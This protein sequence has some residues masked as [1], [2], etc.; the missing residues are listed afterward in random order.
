MR[1]AFL[2]AGILAM[3]TAQVK[4]D[5]HKNTIGNSVGAGETA[6][7]DGDE[8]VPITGAIKAVSRGA[9]IKVDYLR[10]KDGKI[11]LSKQDA[12]KIKG[13][14]QQKSK[15]PKNGGGEAPPPGQKYANY[16]AT[17]EDLGK[18]SR[19]LL[20]GNG[21][22]LT[23][24]SPVTGRQAPTSIQPAGTVDVN[25]FTFPESGSNVNVAEAQGGAQN[26]RIMSFT[27]QE[28]FAFFGITNRGYYA[29]PPGEIPGDGVRPTNLLYRTTGKRQ[30]GCNEV[31]ILGGGGDKGGNT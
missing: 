6:A 28:V 22:N 20:C 9:T 14:A 30:G 19:A 15:M 25:T 4:A 29:V 21:N 16:T 3:N 2:I 27:A 12:L 1:T 24:R 11:A 17:N 13:T 5:E 18:G 8:N 7:V 23:V 10:G 31:V 26:V